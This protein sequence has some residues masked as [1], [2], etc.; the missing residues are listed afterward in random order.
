[1][2]R[3]TSDFLFGS[4]VVGD[5]LCP[6]AVKEED[7]I[8]SASSDRIEIAKTDGRSTDVGS[9]YVLFPVPCSRFPVPGS[10]FPVPCSRFPVPGSLPS[11]HQQPRDPS[12]RYPLPTRPMIELIRELVE[13]LLTL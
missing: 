12:H 7:Q 5:A 3:I 8:R 11:L 1:M 2:Q 4:R 6:G 10:L 13:H 9:A